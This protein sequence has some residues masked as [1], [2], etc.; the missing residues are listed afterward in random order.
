M[1]CKLFL[2]FPT[3]DR[4]NIFPA[5]A[6]CR[7]GLRPPPCSPPHHPCF[8][9]PLMS[10]DSQASFSAILSVSPFR[11]INAGD[12][13]Q[14]RES[15]ISLPRG[16]GRV[17]SG[18][19]RG[20]GA[21]TRSTGKVCVISAVRE[22]WVFSAERGEGKTATEPSNAKQFREA[23]NCTHIAATYEQ[24]RFSLAVGT[25][26]PLSRALQGRQTKTRERSGCPLCTTA[27]HTCPPRFRF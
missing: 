16:G 25:V 7:P 13:L 6:P 11:T 1:L 15:R 2:A 5:N 21:K 19:G 14:R 17:S 22:I 12:A 26:E 4:V 20:R 24:A 8:L 3:C 9:F 27:V 18:R 23:E 10:Y